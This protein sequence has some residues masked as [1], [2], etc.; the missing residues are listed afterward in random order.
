M[1]KKDLK[2]YSANLLYLIF[3][4]VNGY[5]KET[6]GN[7]YL[8]LVPTNKSK[9]KMKKYEELWIK[10]RDLIRSK[11]KNLNDYDE[12]HM[13]IKFNS[14]DNSSLNK[15]I[16]ILIVTIVIRTVFLENNRYYPQVFLDERL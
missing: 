14:D 8:T 4:K 2:I 7:K 3:G 15:T 9:E 12:K 10:I 16:Q 1:I 13:K 5:F 6:N 11:T